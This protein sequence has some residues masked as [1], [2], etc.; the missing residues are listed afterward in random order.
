MWSHKQLLCQSARWLT[1]LALVSSPDQIFHARPADSSTRPQGARKKLVSGDKTTLALSQW[2]SCA[3]SGCNESS[4]LLR[5]W[6]WP[7]ETIYSRNVAWAPSVYRQCVCKVL[8]LLLSSWLCLNSIDKIMT[9]KL[10]YAATLICTSLAC[11]VSFIPVQM[12]LS[13]II[14]IRWLLL[15]SLYIV[16]GS[17][18]W[19]GTCV[20][21]L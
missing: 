12:C 15:S 19:I 18:Y 8:R 16:Q 4:P 21:P 2:N 3:T 20:A 6:V 13:K 11:T 17:F 5:N 9:G 7:R 10:V 1:G 14:I